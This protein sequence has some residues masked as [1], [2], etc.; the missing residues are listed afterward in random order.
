MGARRVG[1]SKY[2]FFVTLSANV[3]YVLLSLGGLL[4][5]FL[6]AV[7]GG[8]PPKIDVWASLVSFWRAPR[9]RETLKLFKGLNGSNSLKV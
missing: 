7:Q 9:R 1:G 8:G 3:R 2:F 4:V 5:E 6:A